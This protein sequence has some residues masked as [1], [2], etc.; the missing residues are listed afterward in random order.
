MTMCF[1][2]LCVSR[3]LIFVS[4]SKASED[5][6]TRFHTHRN[7]NNE[8]RWLCTKVKRCWLAPV[9]TRFPPCSQ[10]KK[11]CIH[12][13]ITLSCYCK[14]GKLIFH[15]NWHEIA[16]VTLWD[17][18]LHIWIWVLLREFQGCMSV[19]CLKTQ[20]VGLGSFSLV[21]APAVLLCRFSTGVLNEAERT[22]PYQMTIWKQI[23]FIFHLVIFMHCIIFSF[24]SGDFG[25]AFLGLSGLFIT[26]C[27]SWQEPCQNLCFAP[28]FL[29][30]ANPFPPQLQFNKNSGTFS[31]S[32]KLRYE[33]QIHRVC[34]SHNYTKISLVQLWSDYLRQTDT[35][36]ILQCLFVL[37]VSYKQ[38][39]LQN[40]L[41]KRL[42]GVALQYIVRKRKKI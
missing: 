34:Y 13:I 29:L 1:C 22:C 3:F 40:S 41:A 10:H 6:A 8:S 35:A 38:K 39:L 7:Q 33:A 12:F 32:C 31:I 11:S 27:F 24:V 26:V 28:S 25:F 42:Q 23:T 14:N 30:P 16:L 4:A 5:S 9:M 19:V 37:F 20:C 15:T 17:F 2:S 36:P 18:I 21:A